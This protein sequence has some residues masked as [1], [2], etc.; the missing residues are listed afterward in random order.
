[1]ASADA[2]TTTVNAQPLEQHA[3]AV[4]RRTT[5]HSSITALEGGTVCQ[6]IHPPQEG[7]RSKGKEDPP[8]ASHST[9]AGDKEEEV[10]ATRTLLPN[11]QVL[12]RDM[13][14]GHTRPFPSQLLVIC[15]DH[16]TL[17]K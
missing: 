16:H 13:E 5:G 15:Q 10:V 8:V 9:K 14:A 17:P 2:H 6:D 12:D 7:H 11:D 1:M 3:V 4:A